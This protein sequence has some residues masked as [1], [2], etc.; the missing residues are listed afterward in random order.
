MNTMGMTEAEKKAYNKQYYHDHKDHLREL[1]KKWEAVHKEERKQYKQQ[2]ELQH[3]DLRKERNLKQLRKKQEER[4]FINIQSDSLLPQIQH[5]S[6]PIKQKI[7]PEPKSKKTPEELREQQRI[8]RQTPIYK[9]KR[10]LYLQQ[11]KEN[12][13]QKRSS[14]WE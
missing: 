10:K 1:Q 14:G 4:R 9:E 5:K 2:W 6:K 3:P 11:R 12:I 13:H 7:L 8:Y